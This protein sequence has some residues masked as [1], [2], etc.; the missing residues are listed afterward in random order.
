M[1]TV[2]AI[3]ETAFTAVAAAIPGVVLSC[4]IE[5]KTPGEYDPE[6]GIPASPSEMEATAE[7]IVDQ[8]ARL[9]SLYAKALE[10][11]EGDTL[12]WVRGASFVPRAT[13]SITIG[14]SGPVRQIVF[15]DDLLDQ[16]GALCAVV[17]R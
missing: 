5:R 15:V 10:I 14:D 16:G 8:R 1:P 3:A 11:R 13:D 4:V 7:C 17:C 6:T 9:L 2:S 12:A